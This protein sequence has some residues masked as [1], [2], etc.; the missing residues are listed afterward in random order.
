MGFFSYL[1]STYIFYLIRSHLFW[2]SILVQSDLPGSL[3][4]L[5]G[6][7]RF[8]Q[9]FAAGDRLTYPG[10]ADEA[11]VGILCSPLLAGVRQENG[12]A[13]WGLAVCAD[14][15]ITKS[16]LGFSCSTPLARESGHSLPLSSFLP[17]SLSHFLLLPFS[18]S[19]LPSTNS[20]WQFRVAGLSSSQ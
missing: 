5:L 8:Y 12:L 17:P 2:F 14:W 3:I 7:E 9:Q 19:F 11:A 4:S 16:Q 6:A 10:S 1:Y 20:C 15:A 13:Y 18:L